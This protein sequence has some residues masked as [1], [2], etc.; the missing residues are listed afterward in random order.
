MTKL[1]GIAFTAADLQKI[2]QIVK[3]VPEVETVQDAISWALANVTVASSD[4][5]PS[6]SINQPPPPPPAMPPPLR[7]EPKPDFVL[8][9]DWQNYIIV[10]TGDITGDMFEVRL[11]KLQLVCSTVLL[12][13]SSLESVISPTSTAV[14]IPTV[15]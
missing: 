4:G 1:H 2:L 8:H 14:S 9:P 6:E 5:K 7:P 12:D 11:Q 15:E 10:P 13:R 3:A